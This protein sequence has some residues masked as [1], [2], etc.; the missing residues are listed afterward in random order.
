[1]MCTARALLFHEPAR[2]HFKVPAGT[3]VE[4]FESAPI[5]AK[6]LDLAKRY[7]CAWACAQI[8]GRMRYVRARDLRPL[9]PRPERVD[10]G[11]LR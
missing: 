8:E 3:V 4:T 10:L 11:D 1:M 7:R 6:L 9:P 5:R 2:G